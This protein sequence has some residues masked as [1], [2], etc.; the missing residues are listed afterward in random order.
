MIDIDKNIEIII[1]KTNYKW[2]DLCNAAHQL[3]SLSESKYDL[4]IIEA[5]EYAFDNGLVIKDYLDDY[6]RAARRIIDIYFKFGKS[7]LDKINKLL[8][9]IAEN[10]DIPDWYWFAKVKYEYNVN[11]N[12]VNKNI[13][14]L[15]STIEEYVLQIGRKPKNLVEKY[16]NLLEQFNHNLETNPKTDGIESPFD[17]ISNELD[18]IFNNRVNQ[19]NIKI[20]QSTIYTPIDLGKSKILIIGESNIS[21]QLILDICKEYG[22]SDKNID[23]INDYDEASNF[24]FDTLKDSNKYKVIIL[25]PTKHK[26]KGI[27][28][29]ESI[30][31]RINNEDGFPYLIDL[32]KDKAYGKSELENTLNKLSNN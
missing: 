23:I 25:G 27:K 21:K 32:P 26:V 11:K 9:I 2:Y 3:H 20:K 6:L 4:R 16:K 12:I 19:T 24:D 13:D 18:E 7:Y 31:S 22:L 5:L 1:N 14:L 15:N 8:K 28:N 30:S 29:Y 10:N 17:S